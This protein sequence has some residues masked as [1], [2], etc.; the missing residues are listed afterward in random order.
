MEYHT[1]QFIRWFRHWEWELPQWQV[2]R[3]S[4]FNPEWE[5]HS[6][7]FAFGIGNWEGR[8]SKQ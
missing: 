8:G 1:E 6:D 5:Y 3:F 2:D 4:P 7:L